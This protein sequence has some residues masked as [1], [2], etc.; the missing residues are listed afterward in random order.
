[1]KRARCDGAIVHAGELVVG[2]TTDAPPFG[3]G[4]ALERYPDGAVAWLDG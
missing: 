2:L 4:L 1:M 3:P